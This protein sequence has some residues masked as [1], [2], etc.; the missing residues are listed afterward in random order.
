MGSGLLLV[1]NADDLGLSESINR[2]IERCFREGI[3]RSASLMP[4]GSA[5]G[6]AVA[7]VKRNPGLGV[8]VHLTLVDELGLAPRERLGRMVDSEGRLPRSYREFL[9]GWLRGRYGSAEVTAEVRAQI[10]RVREAGL[11]PTHLDS[12]QHLHVL[13]EVLEVVVAVAQAEG[14]RVVRVPAE[15]RAA[16]SAIFGTRRGQRRALARLARRGAARVRGAGLYHAERF[17]GLAE[18]GHLDEK[19]LLRILERLGPGVNELMCHP[20]ESDV[21]TAKR[22]PW[23]YRWEEEAATLCAPRVRQ[24][25]EEKGIRLCN[26][27][28]AWAGEW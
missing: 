6:E 2:G 25:I 12:H 15:G 3:V 7:L 27:G 13:P 21:S 22:Y 19:S 23:G 14:I 18:S 4:N 9:W 16:G 10:R 5:F 1:V 26:F 17:W 8:G 24:V 20:G 11:T 28:E